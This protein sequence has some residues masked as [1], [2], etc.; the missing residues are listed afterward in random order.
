M[1]ILYILAMLLLFSL[2][3]F[4]HELGHF[5]AAR[6]FGM[7]ADVFSIGMGRALWKKKVGGTTYQIGVLPF[8]GFV[9][10]PQMDPNSFL[11]G[12]AAPRPGHADPYDLPRVAPW[13]K[14]LVSVAGAAGNVAFAFLLATAVWI[15]GKP[16]SIQERNGIIGYIATNSPALELGLAVGDEIVA[17]NGHAVVGW[18]QIM[19]RAALS[20]TR[21]VELHLR[22]RGG[23]ERNVV[24]QTEK[25]GLGLWVL[26]G[27]A[28]M[29]PCAIAEVE[30]GSAAAEAGL[31][32]GDRLLRF[33][34]QEIFSQPHLIQMVEAGAGRP[35][36]LEF[37]RGAEALSASLVPRYDERR[38]RHRMGIAFNTMDNLDY[39]VL[40][41]PT[42][43]A[44]VREHATG[45]FRFLGA[46]TT[47][48]TAGVAADA[49]GGPVMILRMLWLMLDASFI[50]AIWFTGLLNVNL[51]IINLLPLPILDGGHVVMNVWEMVARRPAPPKLVNALAN[52]FAVLFIA[53]FLLLV[54][55]DSS[56]LLVPSVQRWFHGEGEASGVPAVSDET[57]A[58]REPAIGESST[59][60]P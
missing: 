15:V 12:R 3:I 21:D 59:V 11:E 20:P 40:S 43:W 33:D 8:G 34:G 57:P 27:L 26:P 48:A 16:S 7:V 22:S 60:S 29:E 14:I 36:V 25:S 49:V 6:A 53:L 13:K 28:G 39:D 31:R 2:S 32:P 24:L 35:A 44:Q 54:F 17:V 47:P 18:P 9:S 4:V 42:P 19:E 45:I 37:R 51:A 52:L 56:R 38:H 1:A 23:D 50:L 30:E 10:L 41:H 58:G 55:R 46:L 5:L